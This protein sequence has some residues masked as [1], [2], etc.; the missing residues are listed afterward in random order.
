MNIM[1]EIYLL[2]P[3]QQENLIGFDYLSV[4]ILKYRYWEV[5]KYWISIVKRVE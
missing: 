3:N 1:V 5:S 4:Q 2:D